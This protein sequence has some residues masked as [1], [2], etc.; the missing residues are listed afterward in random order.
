MT[1]GLK[2]L[3]FEGMIVSQT[4]KLKKFNIFFKIFNRL[5]QTSHLQIDLKLASQTC[6]SWI[7]AN[8]LLHHLYV[9]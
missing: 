9:Q 3:V 1:F 7:L 4:K 6:T 5:I 2:I 8:D